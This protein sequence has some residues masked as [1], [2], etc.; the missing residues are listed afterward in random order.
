M[1]VKRMTQNLTIAVFLLAV[2]GFS[3]AF[4]ILPDRDFSE[5][6]NRALRTLPAFT[7]EKLASGKFSDE[8]NDYFADQFPIRDALVGVKGFAEIAMG[9]RENDGILL[10]AD[11]YL[12]K[13][14]FD[15][16]LQNGEILPDMDAFDEAHVR[17]AAEAIRRVSESLEV[18]FSVFLTGRT[19]DVAASKLAYPS[20]YSDALLALL[21]EELGT[22]EGY[23]DSVPLYRER[24]ENGEDVYYR[25]DHHWTTLGAYYAYVEIL[26]SYGLEEEILPPDAFDRVTASDAFYGT[27]WSAGGMK[28]VSPDSIELWMRGNEESF[29]VTADG[30][31][32]EGLYSYRYLDRKDQYSIFLDGTHDVVT[33][34]SKTQA[35]R[36]TLLLFKDSFANSVAPFLAQHFDLVLLNLSSVRTDYTDVSAYAEQY[37]ADYVLLIY[38]LENVMT[39]SKMQ[40]LR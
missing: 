6:E 26:H 15:M 27:S 20:S 12:A 16:M 21:R 11:G 31:E 37:G 36:P 19:V 33:V 39:T 2:F 9:K 34:R 7:L 28:F 13:R 4:W 25:T 38:T 24:L 3:L 22:M 29:A 30:R 5:Q 35:D 40:N 8:I 14:R 23:I 1:D 17:D 10:G 18:P 32:L